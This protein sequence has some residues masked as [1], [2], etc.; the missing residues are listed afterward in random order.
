[1]ALTDSAIIV[2]VLAACLA[3]TA[4]GAALFRHYSPLE[5][6]ARYGVSHEQ[7]QYMRTVRMRNFNFLRQESMGGMRDLESRYTMDEASSYR[8]SQPYTMYPPKQ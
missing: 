2:I 1:M 3:V 8:S 5:D 6:E 4:M 7:A